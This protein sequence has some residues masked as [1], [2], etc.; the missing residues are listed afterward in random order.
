MPMA[1]GQ[2]MLFGAELDDGSLAEINKL[3]RKKNTLQ[4][5]A[6]NTQMI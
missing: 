4:H 2:N 1:R 5:T 3:K 6:S